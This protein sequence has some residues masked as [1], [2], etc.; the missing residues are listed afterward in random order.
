MHQA[1]ATC[2]VCRP[3]EHHA[4][5]LMARNA[6]DAAGQDFVQGGFFPIWT[7]H[8][9]W[10]C[11]DDDRGDGGYTGDFD[12]AS[13]YMKMDRVGSLFSLYLSE[14]GAAWNP[15]IEWDR[16]DLPD[17]LQVGLWQATYSDIVNTG[18]LDFFEIAQGG[19]PVSRDDFSVDHTYV[20]PEPATMLLL[21]LGVFAIRRR[22]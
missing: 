7:G 13:S 5:G 17:T 20:V 3:D 2:H 10:S 12:L 16:P 21:G 18:S 19:Y 1:Q 9:S 4:I 15:W 22:K 6:D 8:L 11:E 14:D